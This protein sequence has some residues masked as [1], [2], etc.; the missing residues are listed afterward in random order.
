MRF[1]PRKRCDGK[2]PCSIVYWTRHVLHSFSPHS[3]SFRGRHTVDSGVVAIVEMCCRDGLCSTR[4][5]HSLPLAGRGKSLSHLIHVSESSESQC[6]VSALYTVS[7]VSFQSESCL[8]QYLYVMSPGAASVR[9]ACYEYK[10]AKWGSLHKVLILY[11]SNEFVHKVG[12]ETDLTRSAIS[13]VK[14]KLN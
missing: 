9:Y 7:W 13:E 12:T 5:S 1:S 8:R 4:G 14:V 2:C 11:S 6:V 10:M 3:Y